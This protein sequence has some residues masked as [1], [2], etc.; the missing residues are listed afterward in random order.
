MSFFDDDFD[1]FFEGFFGSDLKRRK[2]YFNNFE[3]ENYELNEFIEGDKKIYFILDLSNIKN[4]DVKIKDKL[5]KNEFGEKLSTGNKI[6]E[7]S[8]DNNKLSY[9]LSK[10]IKSKNFNW[11][12]NNGILEVCFEK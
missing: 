2:N 7:I 9:I 11:T 6:L 3:E 12:F 10:K 5:V 4:V 8:I 1:D